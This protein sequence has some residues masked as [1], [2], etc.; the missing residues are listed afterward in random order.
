[1][2][3]NLFKNAKTQ[4][5][6][7]NLKSKYNLKKQ[8]FFSASLCMVNFLEYY[9]EEGMIE[10]MLA[11]P[12]RYSYADSNN[13][14]A[15]AG[16]LKA[17]QKSEDITDEEQ[18][19][20]Y[21]TAVQARLESSDENGWTERFFE[22]LEERMESCYRK[23][24]FIPFI[25]GADID[26][27]SESDSYAK[28]CNKDNLTISKVFDEIREEYFAELRKKNAEAEKKAAEEKK[29]S[30]AFDRPKAF[31]EMC[32]IY[33]ELVSKG[34][35]PYNHID[36][37]KYY[38]NYLGILESNLPMI[39]RGK[40]VSNFKKL[41]EVVTEY[42]TDLYDEE[43]EVKEAEFKLFCKAILSTNLYEEIY[44]DMKGF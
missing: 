39:I 41:Q 3:L 25:L 27:F 7:N 36:T 34:D 33:D 13:R 9:D 35:H 44:N 37:D 17:E 14:K 6:I 31:T 8:D 42:L 2:E 24:I 16:A 29:R 26:K 23:E 1:M 10:I 43:A 15:C 11:C 30:E 19:M 12:G 18:C 4:E 21:V 22:E 5:V 32:E 38:N 40:D 20:Y 28:I